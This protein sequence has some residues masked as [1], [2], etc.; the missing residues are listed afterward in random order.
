[1]MPSLLKQAWQQMILLQQYL[2]PQ[3]VSYFFTRVEHYG[4][5]E[6]N[7]LSVATYRD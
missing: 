2:F 6:Q 1:M 7:L 4:V 5:V 3:I